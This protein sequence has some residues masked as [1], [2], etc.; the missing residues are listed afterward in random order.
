MPRRCHDLANLCHCV[1]F[2]FSCAICLVLQFSNLYKENNN[3]S[4]LFVRPQNNDGVILMWSRFILYR[5]K[6]RNNWHSLTKPKE[7]LFLLLPFPWGRLGQWV[8]RQEQTCYLLAKTKS[9]GEKITKWNNQKR[10]EK[11]TMAFDVQSVVWITGA[12]LGP[13]GVWTV[14]PVVAWSWP[15][16]AFDSRPKAI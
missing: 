15:S 7:N 13:I 16:S 12:A 11:K 10:N 5:P 1:T 8:N 4:A 9:P 14:P 6:K 2:W 3:Y